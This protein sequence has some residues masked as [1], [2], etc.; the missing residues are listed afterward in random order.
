MDSIADRPIAQVSCLFIPE[1]MVRERLDREYLRLDKDRETQS[2]LVNAWNAVHN[3]GIRDYFSIQGALSTQY[4]E[5]YVELY[6]VYSP[7]N[8]WAP[9]WGTR[10]YRSGAITRRSV[11]VSEPID[12]KMWLSW[13]ENELRGTMIFA[14]DVY[15]KFAV[16]GVDDIRVLSVLRGAEDLPLKVPGML[17][18]PVEL[19]P[20]TMEHVTTLPSRDRITMRRADLRDDPNGIAKELG[21]LLRLR[22]GDQPLA[23]R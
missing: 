19:S 1:P 21:R 18:L 12:G 4:G 9:M 23:A 2:K 17:G 11:V 7:D 20:E 10:L 16:A 14:A 22:Y 15:E 8:R 6:Q 3:A 5:D 13:F